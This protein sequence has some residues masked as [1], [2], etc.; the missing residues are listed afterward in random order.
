VGV[1]IGEYGGCVGL[2]SGVLI[3]GEAGRAGGR[4]GV[5]VATTQASL[6][7]FEGLA[8]KGSLIRTWGRPLSARPGTSYLGVEAD[9]AVFY[10]KASVG[11][12]WRIAGPGR[13][14]LVTWGFGLGF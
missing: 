14:G 8:L 5:G 7:P 3:Q 1:I 6:F 4:L 2:G 11:Y 10:V 9:V 12:S 13:A